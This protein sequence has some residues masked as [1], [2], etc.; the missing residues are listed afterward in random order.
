MYI[1]KLSLYGFKSFSRKSE[2]HFG[3]GITTVV[4]PNGCGKTN[5]VDAIRWVIGEQKS[6]VLRA[7][8]NTD[9]IFNGTATRRQLNLAEVS[10]TI[11]NVSGKL[12]LPYSDIVISRRVYRNGESEYFINNNL[13]RLKD[14]TDLFIDTGMGANAYSI[15]ELKMI[16]DILSENPEERKRLF[17]EAAGVN[18][19]R[20]QR[21]SAL[22]KLEATKDDLTRL[23]DIISEVDSKVKNLRRQLKRY[24]K[25]QEITQ[26]LIESEVQLASRK[27]ANIKTSLDPIEEHLKNE[28]QKFNQIITDLSSKEEI[29]NTRQKEFEEQENILDEKN[30]ELAEIREEHNKYL[31]SELV[32]KEQLRNIHQTISR[33]QNDIRQSEKTVSDNRQR[34][35]QLKEQYIEIKKTLEYKRESF[36]ITEGKSE[37]IEQQ[38]S[39]INSEIQVLQEKR[40]GLLKQQAEYSARHGSLQDNITQRENELTSVEKQLNVEKDNEQNFSVILDQVR[41]SIEVLTNDLDNYR[42]NFD[43]FEIRYSQLLDSERDLQNERRQVE[44]KLDRLNNQIQFY[45]GI[46]QTKEGFSPG[47]QYVLDNLSDFSGIRG[48]LSDLLSVDPKYYLAVEAVIK[49]ISRLLVADHKKAA[50]ETLEKLTL[51]GKGRVSIIPLDVK[52]QVESSAS[53]KNLTPLTSYIKCDNSL[54]SLKEFLFQQIFCCEDG[55]FDQLIED[56]ALQDVSLVS[57]KGRFRDANGFFS[58]GSESSE[59]GMLI[60]RSEKLY[61]FEREADSVGNELRGIQAQLESVQRDIAKTLNE[62]KML[63]QNI[64][65]QEQKLRDLQEQSRQ[66]ESKYLETKSIQKTLEDNHISLKVLIE[67][68]KERMTRE[69]PEKSSLDTDI[70]AIEGKI[71]EKREAASSVKT[72]LDQVV[73]ERQNRRIELINLENKFRNVADSQEIAGRSIRKAIENKEISLIEKEKN[74]KI[75]VD[76]Q[77]KIQTNQLQLN[78]FQ[79]KV[80]ATEKHIEEFRNAFQGIRSSIQELNE[81][82]YQLRRNKEILTDS[83]SQQELKKSGFNATINE[84]Q[85]VLFEKY[86][87]QIPEQ[88]PEELSSVEEIQRAVDRHKRNLELIG[89]VNMAVKDEYEEENSRLKFLIEQRDDLIKSEKGLNEVILQIDKIAREQFLETFEKIRQNFKSTFSIFFDGGEA[90]LKIIGDSDPLEAQ[91]EIWACPSGKKMRSLKMLSGGEKALTAIALLFG[92]YQVK[93][94]PFCILDEVDAPLDD[95]NTQRFTN[96]IKTFS[97]KTQFIIVTHNKS[98][99]SIADSLYGVTMAESGISQIVSVKLE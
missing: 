56:P 23:Y 20:I 30:S 67:N 86:N 4:G 3:K 70:K 51:T 18:K 31:S 6:S 29:W 39:V 8:R 98:T 76:I 66:N 26:K 59:S 84:I 15:I 17:E 14:I 85:S 7:D 11:H 46:I 77:S 68:F 65:E 5:I 87:Q 73:S 89:M 64:K 22:R 40:F 35:A 32:L 63:S 79:E 83:I 36:E 25:H 53:V 96:V 42:E 45:S 21:K 12:S 82:L 74:E 62:K 27:V 33:L 9:I 75:A 81:Q 72:E 93:P 16:E 24:E 54:N 19:Y 43:K 94:S 41:K 88:L 95:Q 58:G 34:E 52:F 71:A 44:S 48:A 57:D 60:G 13:C 78:E 37:E 28:R 50:L 55:K 80:T 99:M 49:D 91:I 92:I 61:R 10:L 47:L 1:S 90:D 97:E 38:Y 2:I 69:D